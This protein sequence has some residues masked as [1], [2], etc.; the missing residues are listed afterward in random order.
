MNEILRLKYL[1][2]RDAIRP[3]RIADEGCADGGLLAE[4]AQ[5]FP[6]SD[7]Y[8]IDLSAEFAASQSPRS[9]F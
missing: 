2:I 5:D 9:H 6:D 4:I 1:D 8:G 3:G 7:L